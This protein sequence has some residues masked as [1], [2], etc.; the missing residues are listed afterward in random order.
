M[1]VLLAI[2]AAFPA[3][4]L[5]LKP[6]LSRHDLNLRDI[7][8][9]KIPFAYSSLYVIVLYIPPTA[10]LDIHYSLFEI[11]TT[12]DFLY[13]SDVFILGDFNIP[14]YV[15]YLQTMN[16]SNTVLSLI[17]FMNFFDLTQFNIVKNKNNRMLDLIIANKT[18]TVEKAEHLLL[19]EDLHHPALLV[20]LNLAKPSR[21]NKKSNN[22]IQY[23]FRRADLVT[24]YENIAKI[25]WDGIESFKD[26]DS[27]VNY[28]YLKL[29]EVLDRF[30][31]KTKPLRRKYPPWFNGQIIRYIRLKDKAFRDYK[32]TKDHLAL[33][34][35]NLLRRKIKSDI[36]NAYIKYCRTLENNI[37]ENPSKFWQFIN[38]K[39][40]DGN[41]PDLMYYKNSTVEGPENIVNMFA[42]YFRDSYI[43][44]TVTPLSYNN[45]K[46]SNGSE[47]FHLSQFSESEVLTSLKKIKP[48]LTVGPDLIPA[49]LLR[50]C[51]CIFAFPLASLFN[52]SLNSGIFP[53]VWKYSKIIPVFKK[54]DKSNIENFRPI[55][56][57]NNFSKVFELTLYEPTFI[58]MR[59]RIT[60]YQHGFMK[61][62]STITNLFCL[63]QYISDSA[64]ANS[65]VDVIF[66]DFSKAFDR[67]D[68]NTLLKKLDIVGFSTSLLTF[69]DSYLRKRKQFVQY[70]GH[71]SLE[72]TALSGVP[73]GSILGPLFFNIFIN[74]IVR[75]LQVECLLYADD[76]KLFTRINNKQDC[77]RLQSALHKISDWC[78]LNNLPLNAA[79]CNAMTF[80]NKLNIFIY[81]Y[82]I[83]NTIL[84]RP[85][86][87]K[88]L[89]VTL[90][91]KLSFVEHINLVIANCY[92]SLGF[93]IRN[94]RD[95]VNIESIKILYLAFVRSRLDYASI[96]WSPHF[97]THIQNLE[98]VQRRFLKY[99]CF[100]GDGVYPAR[101]HEH[102]AL[103][104]RFSF[105][106]LETRRVRTQLI[107]L[108]KLLHN[109]VD[110][111]SILYLLNFHIP[112]LSS[113][114]NSPFYL[115]TP[116]IDIQKYSPL[117]QLCRNYNKVADTL[118][119]FNCTLAS[120]KN[121]PLL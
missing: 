56:I 49:F 33:E 85:N 79:K 57:I 81:E 42:N 121:V 8:G 77:L 67:L 50:D 6:I 90:D 117:Y 82:C 86:T 83:N 68:H 55:T 112:R 106:N 48:K 21:N 36:D 43:T 115:P 120:I 45:N 35:F 59:N 17:N 94:S 19:S 66:T 76:L 14:D 80:S 89:G 34:E 22:V 118:D 109:V 41:I 88:D 52:L 9:A 10:T 61:G 102:K 28:F 108:H 114:Q 75:D 101:G 110:C 24:L 74:D 13:N 70:S 39:K 65:Q 12:L 78:T 93:I 44:P 107:F 100:K 99:L 47:N 58:Y 103:L 95:F 7:V 53:E 105:E 96:I 40:H 92:K 60:E 71:Q 37:N 104:E 113:R 46:A 32:K 87:F 73:Q 111:E 3:S 2:K 69:F 23:N 72:I 31:P 27:A 4:D 26:V 98:K 84:T 16:P 116:R 54:G 18:G 1:G 11:L 38:N 63:T 51:A 64:D 15:N 97:N 30:V 25:N 20:Y 62:R 91:C 119:I 5:N 29:Y